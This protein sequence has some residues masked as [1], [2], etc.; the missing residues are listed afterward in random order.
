MH[1]RLLSVSK[2]RLAA[3]PDQ[4]AP[5]AKSAI[6]CGVAVSKP[7]TSSMPASFG[8]AIVKPFEIM[9]TT[10]SWASMPDAWR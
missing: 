10:T 8:S 1:L 9:P 3:P 7:T 4:S 5:R 2:G 6:S